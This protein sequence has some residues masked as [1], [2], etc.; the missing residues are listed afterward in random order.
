MTASS[1]HRDQLSRKGLPAALG[2]TQ[3]IGG[4]I[5]NVKFEV[6]DLGS[7]KDEYELVASIEEKYPDDVVFTLREHHYFTPDGD[8]ENIT[9]AVPGTT[10]LL[11]SHVA[12]VP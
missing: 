6:W 3:E 5:D 12:T 9:F 10:L 1:R 7:L 8:P 2:G 11:C 4:A